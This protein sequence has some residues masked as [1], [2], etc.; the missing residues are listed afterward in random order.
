M[1][2]QVDANRSSPTSEGHFAGGSI[3]ILPGQYFY[4]ETGLA[5]NYFRDYDPQT[6]R[7]VQSDP[8]GLAGGINSY[9]YVGANS[10]SR[11]DALGLQFAGAAAPDL[12]AIPS[13]VDQI[14]QT[15]DGAR[16][17]RIEMQNNR[18]FRG[19]ENSALRHC[20]A[21]CRMAKEHGTTLAR[22]FGVGNELQGLWVIDRPLVWSYVA[23]SGSEPEQALGRG[24]IRGTVPWA[25]QFTD[26]L[27]NE[28]GIRCATSSACVPADDNLQS[29]TLCCSGVR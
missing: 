27:D 17:M 28:R 7:Y 24:R 15:Y 16:D 23:A 20:V 9:F 22:S 14:R 19:E 11:S 26:M 13:I 2:A 12:T 1:G 6:G 21:T 4:K 10:V 8:I 3:Q 18:F 29:C 25:F 5:Y